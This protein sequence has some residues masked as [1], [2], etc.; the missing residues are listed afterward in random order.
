MLEAYL[1]IET[2]GLSSTYD[3]ITV[4]GIY[5]TDG[6]SER[7][8]QLVSEEVTRDSI[9]ETLKGVDTIYTYNGSRFDLP[10]L[11]TSL[12]LDLV[13]E[14][15]HHDLMLDCW[16]SNLY[17]GFKAVEHQ[18]GISRHTEGI[19]GFEAVMLWRLYQDNNDRNALNLLL[20]Y[21]REDVVNLKVLR[22][23][24]ELHNDGIVGSE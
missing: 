15:K 23:R 14:F 3:A 11:N 7:F 5:L 6:S 19:G 17:G 4:V 2:T 1:D 16:R 12:G 22:E 13:R 21:N 8:V 10:F 9:L 18:L 20:Q 24:L